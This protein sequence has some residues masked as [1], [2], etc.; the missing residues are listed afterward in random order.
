M[1]RPINQH[2]KQNIIDTAATLFFERGFYK[3]SVDELVAELRI[4]KGTIYRH[5]AN[6]EE[7]VEA[8]L[9]QFNERRN[10]ELEAI[11]RDA[12]LGFSAKLERVTA[13]TGQVLSQINERFYDDLRIHYPRLWQQYEQA[14]DWRLDNYYRPMF[15]QGIAQGILRSDWS[16]PFLLLTYRK[17]TEIVIRPKSLDTLPITRSDAYKQVTQLFLEGAMQR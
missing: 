16:L 2:A 7:I 9:A 11:V 3:V 17:L 5:F 8:V 15:E 12:T 10:A 13:A 14:R 6:K 4:S 1:A